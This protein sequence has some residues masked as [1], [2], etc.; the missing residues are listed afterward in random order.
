MALKLSTAA[1]DA[2]L[3]ALGT[4]LNGGRVRIYSG[5]EPATADTAL[6][7]QVLLAELTFGSPAFNGTITTSGTDRV[8]TANAIT[9]DSAADADGTA[10]FF[11]C[12]NTAGST[13]YY[14]G[15]VGTSGQQLNL[16]ATNIV[17]GG[18]VSISSLTVA[19]PTQ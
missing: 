18:V 9:Q 17:T 10:S 19:M 7:A 3:S 12:T 4:A 1:A 14:Q 2:M 6:G 5:T 11:R 8:M 15:T 16:T 13:T